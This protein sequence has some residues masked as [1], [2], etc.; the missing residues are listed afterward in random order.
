MMLELFLG[1]RQSPF[2]VKLADHWPFRSEADQSR[3]LAK[4]VG[5]W[6]FQALEEE[7]GVG[8]IVKS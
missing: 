6:P 5:N 2:L 3:F 1:A 7:D 8:A 4:S